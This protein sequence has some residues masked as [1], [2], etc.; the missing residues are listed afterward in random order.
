MQRA[1][2]WLSFSYSILYFFV[3]KIT[4]T[5]SSYSSVGVKGRSEVC[6]CVQF[7]GSGEDQDIFFGHLQ[8][9]PHLN[10]HLGEDIED[11]NLKWQLHN[12]CR[13]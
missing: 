12:I 6:F 11:C 3:Q 7:T 2:S 10:H 9:K 13:R 8:K 4:L 5:L 1:E